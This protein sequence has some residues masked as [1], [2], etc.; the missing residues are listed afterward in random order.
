MTS[1]DT[2]ILTDFKFI[3]LSYTKKQITAYLI[4]WCKKVIE[5]FLYILSVPCGNSHTNSAQIAMCIH[6]YKWISNTT[7]HSCQAHK[8][9]WELTV[10]QEYINN[11]RYWNLQDITVSIVTRLW[12]RPVFVNRQATAQYRALASII[13]GHERF[14]WKLSF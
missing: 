10:P 6:C 11:I 7:D 1:T 9:L 3:S 8:C 14:S 2:F 4:I 12:T 13:P 5:V